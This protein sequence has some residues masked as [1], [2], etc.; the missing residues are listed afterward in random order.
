MIKS[1]TFQVYY[2]FNSLLLF[3]MLT[4]VKSLTS[5]L[6]CNNRWTRL[7]LASHSR[8]TYIYLHIGCSVSKWGQTKPYSKHCSRSKRFFMLA[9]QFS[10]PCL[11]SIKPYVLKFH[12]LVTVCCS[13]NLTTP[14][15]RL[16]PYNFEYNLSLSCMSQLEARSS[17]LITLDM[18][19]ILGADECGKGT[20]QQ[21]ELFRLLSPVAK[22]YTAKQAVAVASEALECFGGAGFLEDTGLP[23]L[24][25]DA[26]VSHIKTFWLSL[27]PVAWLLIWLSSKA[28][29]DDYKPK[30]DFDTLQF[31]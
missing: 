26:Q 21:Q 30:Y 14:S 15:W 16:H 1:H 23:L 9:S 12:S 27:F 2:S 31:K 10:S 3:W 20:K 7:C 11:I 18:A 19:R 25:R 8:V 17:L 29:L 6:C 22:L 13:W 28:C 24:L 5:P 4:L